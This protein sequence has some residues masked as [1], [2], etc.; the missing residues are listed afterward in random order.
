M[1]WQRL[2]KEEWAPI[3]RSLDT[4]CT[5]S[6]TVCFPPGK[7][8]VLHVFITNLLPKQTENECP[9]ISFPFLATSSCVLK[10]LMREES[11]QQANKM[12]RGADLSFDHL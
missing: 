12:L 6:T 10:Y 2:W 9:L 1:S 5:G 11:M 4:S 3:T 7:E 8:K